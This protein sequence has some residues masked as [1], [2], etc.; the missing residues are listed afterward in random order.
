MLQQM[1]SSGNAYDSL[2]GRRGARK[3]F[4][5]EPSGEKRHNFAVS[6]KEPVAKRGA[7]G[8]Q[9]FLENKT[10]HRV[11]RDSFVT[12]YIAGQTA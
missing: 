6:S 12:S 2:S 9:R 5:V 10:G 1:N 3:A 7:N 4:A 11:V 8:S